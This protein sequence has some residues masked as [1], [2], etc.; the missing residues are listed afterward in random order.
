MSIPSRPSSAVRDDWIT[1]KDGTPM[2]PATVYLHASQG[3]A[4]RR[5]HRLAREYPQGDPQI[6]YSSAWKAWVVLTRDTSRAK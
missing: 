5:Y 1:L 3:A 2:S 6:F 4:E